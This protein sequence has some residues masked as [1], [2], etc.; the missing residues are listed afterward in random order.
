MMKFLCSGPILRRG[1][2][3][4]R[5]GA[6]VGN[7]RGIALVLAMGMLTLMSII[8]AMALSTSSTEMGLS[9][10]YKTSQLAFYSTQRAVEYAMTNGDIYA[11]IGTGSVD[12]EAGVHPA[13]I[14]GGTDEAMGLQPRATPDDNR[15]AFQAAGN[16]PPG[17]GSDPTYFEARYYL[18]NV[19]GQGPNNSVARVETQIG[20]IVPK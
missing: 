10:N 3:L 15:V 19:T 20:R 9:G 18:V 6:P 11:G 13:N 7:Q 12:L 14:T 16:L 1:A 5:L 17:S 4:R 8:G 2:V